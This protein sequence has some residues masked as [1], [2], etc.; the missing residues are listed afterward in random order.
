MISCGLRK[1]TR[2]SPGKH[3][4]LGGEE[5]LSA[6]KATKSGYKAIAAQSFTT[7]QKTSA[8]ASS[9][10]MAVPPMMPTT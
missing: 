10:N 2:F 3:S 1:N 6:E 8:M 5:V 4:V 7:I 9:N